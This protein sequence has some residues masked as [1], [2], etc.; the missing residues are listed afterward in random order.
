MMGLHRENA[1]LSVFDT[2]IRI[3]LWWQLRCLDSRGRAIPNTVMRPLPAFEFG[4]VHLPLNVND[5]DLHPHMVVA[6]VEHEGPTEMI[7]VISQGC[8]VP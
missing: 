4:D 6:P 1:D 3:R 7:C 5:A 2:E 8:Q